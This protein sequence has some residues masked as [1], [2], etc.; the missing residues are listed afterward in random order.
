MEVYPRLDCS[1]LSHR[2]H[3]LPCRVEAPLVSAQ[4][5]SISTDSISDFTSLSIPMPYQK[6]GEVS[7][8][9]PALCMGLI[10]AQD[11]ILDAL[12]DQGVM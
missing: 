3:A 10:M 4:S 12:Q 8:S 6:T 1:S 5:E 7:C 9:V 2:F 11:S